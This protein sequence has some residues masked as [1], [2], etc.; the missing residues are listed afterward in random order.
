MKGKLTTII[1]LIIL[2]CTSESSI[3]QL[4]GF[5][6]GPYFEA[7]WPKGDFLEKNRNGIGLGIAADIK[8]GA[9]INLTGSAGYL[10]F[11]GRSDGKP[12]PA[13]PVR[14]GLKYKLPIIYLKMESGT[15]RMGNDQGTAL[16]RSPGIGVRIFGLDVQGS[17]ESWLADEGRSFA[18]LKIAYHF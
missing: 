3:A 9:G 11:F 5:S 6:I 17:Y 7:A 2:L 14:I 12:L 15:A 13:F 1:L 4:K 8:L 10:R 16:I 18:A